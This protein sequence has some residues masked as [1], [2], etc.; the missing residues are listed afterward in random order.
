MP[1]PVTLDDVRRA[2]AAITPHVLR[3]PFLASETLSEITGARVHLKFENHQFTASFKERGALA[4]LLSLSGGERARGVVA[5][6]AGNHAQ[7]VAR[8]ARRLGIPA[9]IVMP[10]RTP[11]LKVENTRRL[12]AE[13]VLHGED[14]GAAADHAAELAAKRGLVPVPPY[15]DPHVVA[16]QGSVALEM[17]E[18]VPD[19]DALLVPVGGGG[20]LAGSA[21][22]AS[23]LRPGLEVFGAESARWPSFRQALRGEPIACDGPTVA[24][25]IAVARPGAIPL[26]LA[27]GRVADVLLVDEAGFEAAVLL[28]LE[29]EKTLVEGAG[30]AGLAALRA[31]RARFAGRRVGIVLSG[32]NLDLLLLGSIVERGLARD[33][34]L[35]RLRV[36]L[37]DRAGALAAVAAVLAEAGANVV[38]VAHQ[39]AFGALPIQSVEVEFVLATRGAEHLCAI[40]GACRAAGH[41]VVLPDLA[42]PVP[43]GS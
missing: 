38:H 21:V 25:G 10:A 37:P 2:A 17:L 43:S 32:G 20:L 12:G 29:V 15:D 14:F 27:R 11:D 18:D 35:A 42:E 4:K 9:V 36:A 33:G 30:A 28:L 5:A 6:S 13:V 34:R 3:T 41:A 22:V 8:H 16:G 24:E 7:A 23:A 26:A 19:L 1:E 40:A 31:E 39:R